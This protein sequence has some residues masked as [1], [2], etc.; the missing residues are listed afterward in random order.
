ML[1]DFY[2]KLLSATQ[3]TVIEDYYIHDLSL[4]EIALNLD[5]SRQGVHDALKRAEKK[6]I[7]YEEKLGLTKKFEYNKE[8]TREIL[9]FID[10][11]DKK[12]KELNSNQVDENIMNIKNMIV[13][14]LE[15]S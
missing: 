2:G 3:Y 4:S 8:K 7:S 9:K 5:I 10:E 11:I 6:L 15:T 12:A 14:I 13:D 1:F